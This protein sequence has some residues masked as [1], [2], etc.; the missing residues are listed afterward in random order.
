M[1]DIRYPI[2]I[3]DDVPVITPPG[4]IDVNTAYQLR[5]ALLHAA[6]YGRTTIVVD[7][8]GTQ[9]C[10]SAGVTVLVQAHQRA[11]AEGAELRLVIPA[12]GAVSRIFTI[13]GLHGLIPRFEGLSDALLPRPAAVVI[14]LQP[15]RSPGLPRLPRQA[16]R[17]DAGA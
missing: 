14:P 8:T 11:L 15:G 16:G 9:F 17:S 6:A 12:G 10:D 13:T 2:K 5:L 4:E 3:I 7:M 1:H